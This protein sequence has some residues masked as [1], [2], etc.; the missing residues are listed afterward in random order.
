MY[1]FKLFTGVIC[2]ERC[3]LALII[4][5]IIRQLKTDFYNEPQIKLVFIKIS[6]LFLKIYIYT[7]MRTIIVNNDYEKNYMFSNKN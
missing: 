2:C 3:L 7:F 6:S 1:I 5:N 4:C